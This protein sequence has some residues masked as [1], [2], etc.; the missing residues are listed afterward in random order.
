MLYY[1]YDGYRF[2]LLKLERLGKKKVTIFSENL[3]NISI[4]FKGRCEKQII[5]GRIRNFLNLDYLEFF[6][7]LAWFVNI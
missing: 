7:E 6:F 2:I 5:L 3:Q 1:A 4:V